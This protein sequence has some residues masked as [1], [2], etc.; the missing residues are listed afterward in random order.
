[1][2]PTGSRGF[3]GPRVLWDYLEREVLNPTAMA[4]AVGVGSQGR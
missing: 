3:G 4:G 2:V 1:M